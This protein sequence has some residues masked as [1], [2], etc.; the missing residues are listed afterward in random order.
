[1][2]VAD[3]LVH[4]VDTNEWLDVGGYV[5]DMK[6]SSGAIIKGVQLSISTS[7]TDNGLE[8]VVFV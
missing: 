5:C 3:V 8:H 4:R 6:E 2:D 7:K 1:M